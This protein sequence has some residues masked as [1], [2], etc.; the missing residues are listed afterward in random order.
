MG[1]FVHKDEHKIV[2]RK[3]GL[4]KNNTKRG[5]HIIII[6]QVTSESLFY[7]VLILFK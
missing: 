1:N 5:Y 6:G 7:D 2:S 4:C 3:N